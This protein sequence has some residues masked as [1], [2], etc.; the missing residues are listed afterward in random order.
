ME[1]GDV[2]LGSGVT[3]RVWEGDGERAGTGEVD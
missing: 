1:E 3:E 2:D